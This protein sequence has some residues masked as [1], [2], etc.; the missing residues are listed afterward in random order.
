MF[1]TCPCSGD[2]S[3][4][5]PDKYA[6]NFSIIPNNFY[7][8][9]ENIINHIKTIDDPLL[10]QISLYLTYYYQKGHD[11]FSKCPTRN[12]RS[13]A[14]QYL[15]Q[16]S[17]H[18]ENIFTCSEKCTKRNKLWKAYIDTLWDLLITNF[19]KK[20]NGSYTP[21]CNRFINTDYNKT[22]IPNNL[23]T[24]F[25]IN[26][27]KY[28]KA[29]SAHPSSTMCEKPSD[30]S[31]LPVTSHVNFPSIGKCTCPE[32]SPKFSAQQSQPSA[33]I[34]NLNCSSDI[35]FYIALSSLF[36][37]LGTISIL[38][39]LYKFTPLKSWIIRSSK[40]KNGI[41]RYINEETDEFLNT[42]EN[43]DMPTKNRRN[44]L[45]YHSMED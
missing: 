14:C 35:K 37:F 22:P 44:H 17:W 7:I 2:N 33:E 13:T 20:N 34:S 43:S 25:D 21:W 29:L 15:N 6:L 41:D 27:N 31:T 30:S 5:T 4:E 42:Y 19:T 38:F 40:S 9:N 10:Q 39:L 24:T 11:N 23:E 26:V 18:I 8:T 1:P 12:N 36:T 28:N 16:W 32:E 45:F 3:H